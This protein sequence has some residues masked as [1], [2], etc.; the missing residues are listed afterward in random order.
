MG[1]IGMGADDQYDNYDMGYE[2]N[3]KANYGEV[4]E[5][6][7]EEY[8]DMNEDDKIPIRMRLY[9]IAKEEAYKEDKSKLSVL[10]ACLYVSTMMNENVEN[11]LKVIKEMEKDT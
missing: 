6:I 8:R 10:E 2:T 4:I 9:N 1:C 7:D 5:Y 11:I 3:G